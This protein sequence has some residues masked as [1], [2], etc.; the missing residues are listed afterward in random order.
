MFN[1]PIFNAGCINDM[2]IITHARFSA[3]SL[4][5]VQQ[6]AQLPQA[7]ARRPTYSSPGTPRD[8][9]TKQGDGTP[10]EH[11]IPW[12]LTRALCLRRNAAYAEHMRGI[13]LISFALTP[14]FPYNVLQQETFRHSLELLVSCYFL[15]TEEIL[16]MRMA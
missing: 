5:S 2:Y 3:T 15:P 13:E 10:E 8:C 12:N 9:L 1:I 11:N 16:V 4:I 6:T 14:T 7:R